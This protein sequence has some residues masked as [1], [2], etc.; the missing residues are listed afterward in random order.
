MRAALA[1]LA[2]DLRQRLRDRSAI[3]TAFVVPMALATIFGLTLHNVSS[4]DM[5]FDYALVDRDGGAIAASFREQ[6]LAPLERRGLVRMHDAASV[7]QARRLVDAQGWAAAFVLPKGLS[8]EVNA[9]RAGRIDVIGNADAQVGTLV[10]QSIAHAFADRI[11]A[12]RLAVAAVLE[13]PPRGAE[14]QA[15]VRAAASEVPPVSVSDVSTRRKNLDMTTFYAAGMAVFFLFYS[16]QLGVSSLLD[17]RRDGTLARLLAA[18]IP[19]RSVL[20]GKLLTSVCIGAVSM[21]VLALAT[22]FLLGAHWGNPLGVAIL[23]GA[24]VLA[25]TTIMALVATLA[26][27][28][29]QVGAWQSM[30]ALVL[31]MLG[32]SFFPV[33]QAGGWLATLSKATPH[34]W[35]LRGLENLSGGGGATQALGPAAVILLIAAVTGALA[36]LRIGKLAEP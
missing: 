36:F 1:I 9:G 24:G 17:E 31:G 13:G 7:A 21:G 33:A 6:V 29:D 14:G 22:H 4:G 10:A 30:V 16:V 18:P 27:T 26:K 34:A 28:Q 3:L 35:F 12:A 15:V 25:A 32:G 5:R 20:V 8:R 23:I 11:S 2:N 19:R